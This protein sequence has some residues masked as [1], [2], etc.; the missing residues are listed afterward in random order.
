MMTSSVNQS[1]P[2]SFRTFESTQQKEIKRTSVLGQD[3][4]LKLLTTQLQHQDPMKPMENGEFMGQMAQFSTVS[5][6]TEMGESIDSLVSIY[7]GQQ[8]SNSASMIGKQA[9]VNGNW[10]QLKDGQLGG[11]I[12]LATAVNDVRI[13]IK[14][15]TGEIMASLGLGSKMA[16]TQ[17]FSWD[18]VKHDGTIAT[19]GNYYLSATAIRDGE[20][21]VPPMQV[22]GTVS[23]IQLKGGEVTLNVSGQGNVSFNNVKRISQ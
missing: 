3:D 7:Q 19:E 15:E 14:S 1:I 16:G 17:E 11:A 20:T 12:D 4:F 5:G 23:S 2:E 21:T 10:T 18:G 8:M 13:D 9:L 6:I 22:Y